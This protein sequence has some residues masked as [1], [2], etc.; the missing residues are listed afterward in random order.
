VSGISP[1]PAVLA[2][3]A[4]ASSHGSM[5]ATTAPMPMKKLCIA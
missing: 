2:T 1:G 5:L 3:P 4:W